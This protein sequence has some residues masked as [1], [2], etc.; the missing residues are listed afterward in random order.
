MNND[1]QNLY[2]IYITFI[3][4]YL[5]FKGKSMMF[6]WFSD[7]NLGDRLAFIHEVFPMFPRTLFPMRILDYIAKI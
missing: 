2:M 7:V 3:L 4:I 6:T 1:F 5:F